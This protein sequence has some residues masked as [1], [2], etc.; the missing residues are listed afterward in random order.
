MRIKTQALNKKGLES[1]VECGALD[2]LGERGVMLAN[3]ELMLKF[4]KDAA[5]DA[6]HDSLAKLLSQWK[7]GVGS[8][9]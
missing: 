5:E 7:P 2:S 3:I 9:G 4:H 8:A 1:L 6:G